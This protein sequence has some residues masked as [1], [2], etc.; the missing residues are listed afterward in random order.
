MKDWSAPFTIELNQGIKIPKILLPSK[1]Q[2]ELQ[3]LATFGNPEFFKAQAKRFSTHRI[4]RMIDCIQVND[5]MLILPRGLL[6]K[7]K[8]IFIKYKISLNILN[9]QFEGK[10]IEQKFMAN[11]LPNKRMLLL[12]WHIMT[13]EY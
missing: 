1:I 2:H 8:G 11:L 5:E 3:K 10:S 7:V 9:N 12:V 4:P 6:E 13:T